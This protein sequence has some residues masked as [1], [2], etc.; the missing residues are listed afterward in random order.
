MSRKGESAYWHA[1]RIAMWFEAVSELGD[2]RNGY[3]LTQWV[4]SQVERDPVLGR[5][6]WDDCMVRVQNGMHPTRRQIFDVFEASSIYRG[7]KRI[8][9]SP[10][11]D[12]LNRG[13]LSQIEVSDLV[14]VE[15]AAHD[16][17]RLDV[18]GHI[19]LQSQVL[20]K[21]VHG[22]A[23]TYSRYLD[24]AFE[25]LEGWTRLTL[26]ALLCA[27]ACAVQQFDVTEITKRTFDY[28]VQ[29]T[30]DGI[31]LTRGSLEDYVDLVNIVSQPL[32]KKA[33]DADVASMIEGRVR[34]VI[35]ER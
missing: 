18:S 25:R 16:L 19:E 31:R 12:L 28:D 27:E 4:Y 9:T 11:W 6:D 14:E 8:Y 23:E 10:L 7:T 24:A 30:F 2:A 13:S 21:G 17:R 5:L 22:F 15:L 33:L 20:E 1:R 29:N 35:V 34:S 3:A 26:S 32:F